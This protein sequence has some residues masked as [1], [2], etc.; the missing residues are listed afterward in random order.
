MAFIESADLSSAILIDE[1]NQIT[2]NDDTVI[3]QAILAAEAEMRAY[4]YDSF[5][6]DMIFTKTGADRNALLVRYCV[7][8]TVWFIVSTTQ[9]GQ[10]LSDREAR[11]DRA[12]RWL[13]MVMK[14]ETY[15][16]LPRRVETEQDHIFTGSSNPKRNNYF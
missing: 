13:K 4:L 12:C 11:Y 9:A 5:D 8:I 2:R 3:D 7:D 15:A 6:V 16:D 14:S 1:L 10:N